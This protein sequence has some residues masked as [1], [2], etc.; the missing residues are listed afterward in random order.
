MAAKPEDGGND[1]EDALDEGSDGVGYWGDKGK[2]NEGENILGEVEDSIE[3]EFKGEAA[4]RESQRRRHIDEGVT[5][6]EERGNESEAFGPEPERESKQ[7]G[8][9]GAVAE[10]I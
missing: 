9:T 3:D 5:G 10:E 2:E 6:V 7:E 8:K 1:D 4:G